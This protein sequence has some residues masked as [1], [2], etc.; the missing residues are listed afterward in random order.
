MKNASGKVLAALI[1]VGAIAVG[2]ACFW[3]K[4]NEKLGDVL[5]P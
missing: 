1:L 3:G 2:I 5:K 4:L